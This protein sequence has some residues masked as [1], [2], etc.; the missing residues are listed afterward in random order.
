MGGLSGITGCGA[1]PGNTSGFL[2]GG[3][4]GFCDD[5]FF[6]IQLY[7]ATIPEII[8]MII[9]IIQNNPAAACPAP[10]ESPVIILQQQQVLYIRS[11]SLQKDHHP[12]LIRGFFLTIYIVLNE[13]TSI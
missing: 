12:P 6:F 10:Y 9:T 4:G 1:F 8:N 5:A 3:C 13:I 7:P 2:C 11:K